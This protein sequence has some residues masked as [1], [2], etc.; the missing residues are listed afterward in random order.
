MTHS[1]GASTTSAGAGVAVRV[2]GQSRRCHSDGK[3]QTDRERTDTHG[4]LSCDWNFP[5]G[6][7][8]DIF[9]CV[10][11]AGLVRFTVEPSFAPRWP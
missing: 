5:P 6:T 3:N 7:V 9:E 4:S 8:P 2:L 1:T 11:P 10:I